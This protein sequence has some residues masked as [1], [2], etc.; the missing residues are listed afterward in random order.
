MFYD[1]RFG[2]RNVCRQLH[3]FTNHRHMDDAISVDRLVKELQLESPSP[4]LF[5]KQDTADAEFPKLM[6]DTFLLVIMASFQAS[7][8]EEFCS[9]VTCIDS[10]HKTNE[11]RFKLLTIVVPDEYCNGM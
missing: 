7:I 6:K 3:N 4:V 8:F 1:D 5:Y 10:T 2:F 11:Y 9:K